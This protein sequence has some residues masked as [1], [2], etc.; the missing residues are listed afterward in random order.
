MPLTN[1]EKQEKTVKRFNQCFVRDDGLLDIGKYDGGEV[2]KFIEME[3]KIA[4]QSLLES[5]EKDVLEATNDFDSVYKKFPASETA[6]IIKNR[7]SNI[8]HKHQGE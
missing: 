7:I 5:V 4:R 2:L 8:I 3:K 6:I 1:K